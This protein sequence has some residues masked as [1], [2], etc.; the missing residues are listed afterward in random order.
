MEINGGPHQGAGVPL[1]F[2]ASHI[3]KIG[4]LQKL[5]FEF[6]PGNRGIGSRTIFSSIRSRLATKK[7]E[8]EG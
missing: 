4:G 2:P 1:A 3:L 8:V 5:H 6:P 7:K